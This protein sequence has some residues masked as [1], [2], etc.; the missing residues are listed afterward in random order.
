MEELL[1]QSF[2]TLFVV[3]NPFSVVPIFASLTQN[4]SADVKKHVAQ[5]SCLVALLLLLC[6]AV[7]GDKLL[8]VMH[9]SE[10]AFR[11]T[12]GL[13]LLLAAIEMVLGKNT[14][15]R[16]QSDSDA[17]QIE[18]RDD[19][20]IYPLAIPL[21]SGP[22]AIASTVV[23]MRQAEVIGY[24][25]QGAFIGIIFVVVGITYVVLRMGQHVMAFLGM[26]GVNILTRV[27]GIILSS[28]AI[29]N[30]LYGVKAV[31]KGLV[32]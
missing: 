16:A 10:P 21:I 32:S 9:I 26:T 28:L 30:I 13:L 11:V 25:A 1:W 18:G 22:G 4:D 20:S 6:F 27:F 5:K 7:L 15:V 23:L 17:K 2:V 14:G 3:S 19:V 12:G 8:D 24:T 29:Q 31:F